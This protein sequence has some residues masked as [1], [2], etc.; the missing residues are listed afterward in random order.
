MKVICISGKARHGKDTAANYMKKKLELSGKKVLIAHYADLLKYICKTF[1]GWNGVKDENGRQILQY[2][3]TDVIR[4][5]APDYWVD[6]II[7]ILEMFYKN[8]DYVLIPDCRFQNEVKRLR[9]LDFD[10]TSIK[11]VRDNFISELT[12]EQKKHTSEVAM[13]NFN[14]DF[15]IHN[16]DMGS[17][18]ANLNQ[19]LSDI[20]T[21]EVYENEEA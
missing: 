14:F 19:L 21:V 1:F 10:V 9:E 18:Y 4:E 7:S 17:F 16:K 5:Q 15:V 3:G 2:V 11:I 8:W 20:D 12:E 13:D 6:F